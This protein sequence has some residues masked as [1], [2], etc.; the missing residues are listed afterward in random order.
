MARESLSE[1]SVH[2]V[3]ALK[4]L[5]DIDQAG[6]LF[7]TRSAE[8]KRATSCAVPGGYVM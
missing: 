4:S 6:R 5:I 7:A 1:V 8:R 3:N 2:R